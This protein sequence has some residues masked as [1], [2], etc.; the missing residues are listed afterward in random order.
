METISLKFL[1]KLAGKENNRALIS[2]IK[3]N[4]GTKA[5]ERDRICQELIVSKL[6]D[7]TQEISKIKS[8]SAG[9][10][11]L[12]SADVEQQLT[13]QEIKIVRAGKDQF[14][15]P[16]TTNV[17][18]AEIRSQ[19][20]AKLSAQGLITTQK[21]F[22]EVWLTDRGKEYLARKYDPRGGGIITL[23][24]QMLADYLD[25]MRS[26]LS[27]KTT[28]KKPT[29]IEI[30]NMIKELDLEYNTDNYLPIFHLRKE[31]QPPLSRA[32]LNESL[33]RLQAEDKIDL[34]TL[35]E[36]DAYTPAEINAGISQPVGGA[37][38]FITFN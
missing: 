11:I 9:S 28:K 35:A 24:K 26:C 14:V 8:T 1:L 17:T 27:G 7:C 20:I 6:V 16:G 38:F 29:D 4:S 33:Y 2:Q 25:L 12:K 30:L 22:K 23:S 37:L 13:E 19:A 15:T 32:E 10:A 21:K 3:P 31:L 34:S 18:P 5:S 36:A